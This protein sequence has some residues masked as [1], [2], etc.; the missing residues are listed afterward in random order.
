MKAYFNY[1]RAIDL[2]IAIVT[3]LLAY[4]QRDTV[5]PIFIWPN[6][7]SFQ[8]LMVNVSASSASLLGFVL[9][10]NTFLISHTQHRRLALLRQSAGYEQLLQIMRSNLWRLFWLM[11][12]AGIGSLLSPHVMLPALIGLVFALALAATGVATLIWS[13]MATLSIRID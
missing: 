13:T 11:L 3:A 7:S 1:R 4:T 5:S 2:S 10:A 12:Y 9:A 6:P 8:S